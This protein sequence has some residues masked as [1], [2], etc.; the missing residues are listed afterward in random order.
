MHGLDLDAI[1]LIER[2]GINQTKKRKY[3]HQFCGHK[4][5]KNISFQS[6]ITSLLLHPYLLLIVQLL[7]TTWKR[8]AKLIAF[9]KDAKLKTCLYLSQFSLIGIAVVKFYK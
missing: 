5:G 6:S 9:K 4:T 8:S 3:P 2:F 1:S 7:I